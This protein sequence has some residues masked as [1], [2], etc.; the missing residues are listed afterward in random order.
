MHND[1]DRSDPVER[2]AL[3]P[4]KKESSGCAV[5]P[6][7][8]AGGFGSISLKVRQAKPGGVGSHVKENT[9]ENF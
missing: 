1:A 2:S 3:A 8:A 5:K 7:V 9:T 4:A 6:P